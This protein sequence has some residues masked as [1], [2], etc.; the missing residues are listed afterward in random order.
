MRARRNQQD[1]YSCRDQRLRRPEL[2]LRDQDS[3]TPVLI[4]KT[5]VFRSVESP[6]HLGPTKTRS[7]LPTKSGRLPRKDQGHQ[8]GF[9]RGMHG[10]CDGYGALH[11]VE[12]D[13]AE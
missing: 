9:Y 10:V 3:P 12:I 13:R 4:K 2:Q 7:S 6:V 1:D 5:L 11:G 8:R